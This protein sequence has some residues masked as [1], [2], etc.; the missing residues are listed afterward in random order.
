MLDVTGQHLIASFVSEDQQE[1]EWR[2]ETEV[3]GRTWDI[4]TR[5]GG[6][7]F[8]ILEL[9]WVGHGDEGEF[10]L[11]ET[12]LSVAKFCRQHGIKSLVTLDH[13][14]VKHG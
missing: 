3:D 2:L 14:S 10:L 11:N 8:E 4:A 13:G 5:D 9:V 1:V 12:G 7:T 6:K